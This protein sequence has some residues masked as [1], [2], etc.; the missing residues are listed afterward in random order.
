METSKLPGWL[1]F[2]VFHNPFYLIST[3]LFVYGLKLLF[4]P[5]SSDVL[6]QAGTVGYI[7]PWAL[8]L[9]LSGVTLLMAVT[10][11][12]VIRLGKVWE[13][14][15]SLM[16]IVLLMFLAI[17]VSF[18]EIA[19]LVSE[20]SERIGSALLL[21]GLQAVFMLA[22]T[23]TMLRGMRIRLSWLYRGPLYLLL[24][25][26][27]A[28]PLLLVPGPSGLTSQQVRWVIAAF[29]TAAG[30]LTLTLFPAVRKG[31]IY[32]N[33]N[34]TP[35]RWPLFPWSAFVFVALAVCFRA[36]SLTISFDAPS[37]QSSFWDTSFGLYFL[38]PFALAILFLL[39]EI[40][41][42]E[43]SVKLQSFVLLAAPA[44]LPLSYP[45]LVPWMT[46]RTYGFFAYEVTRQLGSPV[47]L[48]L[49][50]LTVFYAWAWLRGVARGELGV[51]AMLLLAV[52]VG[53]DFAENRTWYL[54]GVDVHRWPLLL[55]G[56]ALVTI[57]LRN[58][59]SRETFLG[60][61]LL[62][63]VAGILISDTQLAEYQK[64]ISYHLVL[65]S[66]FLTGAMFRDELAEWLRLIGAPLLAFSI[67]AAGLSAARGSIDV[68]PAVG[69]TVALSM[70]GWVYGFLLNEPLYMALAGFQLGCHALVG[71]IWGVYAFFQ[72]P[73]KPGLRHVILAAVSFAVAVLI[74]TLKGSRS[75]SG[76]MK[77]G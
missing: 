26:M 59:S 51:I 52:V 68:L 18:D 67:I 15:R 69:Y 39:L 77:P 9:S 76:S 32:C 42:V 57:G 75:R 25:L 22:V 64:I 19:T 60:L 2:I 45:W 34:G 73:L 13:D 50:G 23:E 61:A 4:R 55:L 41:I 49:I 44:L 3:G 47:Y 37:L 29:P 7:P 48:T 58:W 43:R 46:L 65:V 12:A 62:S 54:Q 31:S 72:L 35:W 8:M 16:L 30:L 24:L 27:L 6:F 17:S 28:W 63:V 1:R 14:G 36:Y 21:C 20:Q 56:T 38:V 70:L 53:P 74:S 40:G 66:L 10:A 5:D 71:C 11:I 33:N